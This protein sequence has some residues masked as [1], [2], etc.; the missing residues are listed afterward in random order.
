VLVIFAE[1][2]PIIEPHAIPT[3]SELDFLPV[4][5]GFLH[6]IELAQQGGQRVIPI[7]PIGLSYC[8]AG[9]RWQ[10]ALRTGAPL[11]HDQPA[12]RAA[13]RSAVET[14]IRRLSRKESLEGRY[15][16]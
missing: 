13:D 8:R 4:R 15:G 2:Y 16:R 6:F 7:V 11:F 10:V 9:R 5:P 3:R 14:A 1:G 12:Q